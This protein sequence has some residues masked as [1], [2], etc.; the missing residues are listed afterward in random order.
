M[1]FSHILIILLCHMYITQI[2]CIF[3]KHIPPQIDLHLKKRK[4]K[5]KTL[6][7]SV[8]QPNSRVDNLALCMIRRK[9]KVFF[10]DFLVRNLRPIMF[11]IHK[12]PKKKCYSFYIYIYMKWVQVTFGITLKSYTFF[13]PLD[14]SKSN[15]KK[16]D[17][18]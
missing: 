11:V 5:R 17:T 14:L 13:K 7:Q 4:K 8:Q 1:S 2:W 9:K 6:F 15:G 10:W 16:K 12:P 18:H 3:I